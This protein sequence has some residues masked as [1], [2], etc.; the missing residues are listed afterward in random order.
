MYETL[1][2]I[3]WIKKKFEL[4]ELPDQLNCTSGKNKIRFCKISALTWNSKEIRNGFWFPI[5]F[6]FFNSFN[7][8][9]MEIND[10]KNFFL[11]LFTRVRAFIFSQVCAAAI[12]KRNFHLSKWGQIWWKCFMIYN[13]NILSLQGN[14]SFLKQEIIWQST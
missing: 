2:T 7:Q 5:L 14:I 9:A 3:W 13:M 6:D 1:W 12:F 4:K 11:F 10:I 8:F